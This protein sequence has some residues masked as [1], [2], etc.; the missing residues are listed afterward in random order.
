MIINIV[1]ILY[2]ATFIKIVYSFYFN[3]KPI[4]DVISSYNDE[5]HRVQVKKTRQQIR[6]E[7]GTLPESHLLS[8]KEKQQYIKDAFMFSWQGY[9]NFSWGFDE[10]RPVSNGP[11]NTRNG[12]GATIIDSL[13]TLFI[14]GFHKDFKDAQNF[15]SLLNWDKSD[16][17][18]PVQLFETVIRYVGGLLS[19]YDLSHEKIFVKKAIELVNRL[20][21]AFDT[22][23]GIPY[24]YMNFT[25]GEAIKNPIACL[26]EIGTIQIE[27]T[28]LSEITG[29]WKYHYVGQHVYD[30]F[31]DKYSENF[32]L[33]PHLINVNTGKPV[34]DH[35]TW[36]GMGDSFYE[37]LIKQLVISRGKDPIKSKMVSQLI[38]GLQKQLLVDSPSDPNASFLANLDNGKQIL[39]MD[40]LAC[41]A[42]G[43][44][45]LAAR[46][47]PNHKEVESIAK[48]LMHGCYSAWDLSKTGLAPEIFSWDT[49]HHDQSKGIYYDVN[50]RPAVYPIVPSYILR[51]ET[52]ES[53]YY[54][55]VLTKDPIY[56]DMAWDIFSSLYTYCRS[57]SGYSG[58]RRVD[59]PTP[60]WDD[61]EESFFFAE[62]LKYLYLIFDDPENPR[63]PFDKWVFN[64]EAHP[65]RITS[66]VPPLEKKI[67]QFNHQ[68]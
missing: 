58:V 5:E 52:L 41:F 27:F 1:Y 25:T 43:T 8:P 11:R 40:E 61:R 42:P 3:Q 22:T 12:W 2:V 47:L 28:R 64:T 18:E 33:F 7:L 19:A 16:N 55:F 56:Q 14:M 65:L 35:I 32:G 13:D 50:D 31:I 17:D 53:L 29:N 15:V 9:R 49:N 48:R 10:N 66:I 26:A 46:I 54:F 6:A 59:I 21:P 34:G 51:P 37:Y 4:F 57:K 24:Q 23:T 44:L 67:P 68:Q 60:T 62:T 30:I 20:L 39:Q 45:L 36:G 63:L 38:S